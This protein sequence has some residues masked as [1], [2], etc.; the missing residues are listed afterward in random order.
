MENELRDNL[1]RLAAAY[2]AAMEIEVVTTAR[3]ATGDWRFFARLDAGASFTAKKYDA[4]VDWFA[5]HWPDK[6]PWPD[7]L[8][9]PEQ[10]RDDV[11][12][13]RESACA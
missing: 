3:L 5:S 8:A 6:V 13:P 2:A 12:S 1:R 9:R 11:A 7:N 10:P 4:V